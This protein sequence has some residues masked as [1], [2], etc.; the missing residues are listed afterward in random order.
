M[1]SDILLSDTHLFGKIGRG[2][3]LCDILKR[4][5][6]QQP[7]VQ[8]LIID[9]DLLHRKSALEPMPDISKKKPSNTQSTPGRSASCDP[10]KKMAPRS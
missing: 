2:G 1:T 3:I 9:G 6:R 10:W 7:K 5:R 8:R 4:I